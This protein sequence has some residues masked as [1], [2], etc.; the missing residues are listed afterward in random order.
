M[1]L[2]RAD[3]ELNCAA[4]GAKQRCGPTQLM[5]QLS[6]IGMMK[7]SADPDLALLHELIRSADDRLICHACQSVGLTVTQVSD[8]DQWDDVRHCDGCRQPIPRER[9][10]VFADATRCAACQTSSEDGSDQEREFC[11]QCGSVMTLRLRRS[12]GPT[13]YEIN[14]PNC[15]K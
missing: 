3:I 13:A 8:D 10:E 4:C 5:Q 7:R 2:G 6:Q 12:A 1:H 14:C 11:E 9:L 15:R